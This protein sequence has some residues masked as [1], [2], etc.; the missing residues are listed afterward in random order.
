MKLLEE[1]VEFSRDLTSGI[2]GVAFDLLIAFAFPD[3]YWSNLGCLI[4][5]LHRKGLS[6]EQVAARRSLI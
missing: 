5:D 2:T 4:R 1:R 3:D 6:V